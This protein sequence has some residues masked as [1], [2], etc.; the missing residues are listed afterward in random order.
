MSS[1]VPKV[2][3]MIKWTLNSM[4]SKGPFIPLSPL[5]TMFP[6]DATPSHQ[7]T[8]H[9]SQNH[10][11]NNILAN[12]LR[13]VMNVP[14]YVMHTRWELF[15]PGKILQR[16]WVCWTLSRSLTVPQSVQRSEW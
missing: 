6:T 11:G 13:L 4:V 2:Q 5:K 3:E 9:P 8:Q 16:T 7:H 12:L 15:Q 1:D 14:T 10:T